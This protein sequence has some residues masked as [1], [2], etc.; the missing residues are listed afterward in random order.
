MDIISILHGLLASFLNIYGFIIKKN[1]FDFYYLFYIYL[2]AF[3]WTFYN[4]DCLIT[5]YY[6]KQK[7]KNYKPGNFKEESDLHHILGKEY[8]PFLRKH[9]VLIV[10]LLVIFCILSM[11]RVMVRQNIPIS[12]ILILF[13]IY[14]SYYVSIVNN[15]DLH[16]LF[17]VLLLGCLL[18]FLTI[19]K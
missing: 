2:V 5:Y 14:V 13:T 15:I 18:Y 8:I 17:R 12:S 9:H 4:G 6:N 3:S 1:W 7:N 10:S 11:Y 16:L 19:W